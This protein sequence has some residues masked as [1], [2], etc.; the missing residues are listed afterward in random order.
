MEINIL[1][2]LVLGTGFAV[3]PVGADHC[4]FE[5][6]FKTLYELMPDTV[7]S[8]ASKVEYNPFNGDAFQ[9]SLN[10]LLVWRKVDNW[11]A[12]T[13]GYHTWINGQYGLQSRLNTE[14]F[15]WEP[16]SILS[17]NDPDFKVDLRKI[18]QQSV[19]DMAKERTY[20]EIFAG[21][22]PVTEQNPALYWKGSAGSKKVLTLTWT[23]WDGYPQ[24]E[25]REM[26]A[27]RDIWVTLVPEIRD[28]CAA[29]KPVDP[30]LDLE[31]RLGLPPESGKIYMV[32]IWADPNDMFRP[33][34]DPEISDREAELSF[35]NSRYI[36]ISEEYIDWFNTSQNTMYGVNGHPWTRLGY[37]YDWGSPDSPIGFSEYVIR[38]GAIIEIYQV[39]GNIEYC[40]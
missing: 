3:V 31:Q 39:K 34:P 13:N 19:D 28:Y 17:D 22:I 15:A 26:T 16:E 37:T 38:K 4:K 29:K 7:G 8:C 18:Y 32:E 11:T 5:L 1:L 10:G 27:T 40:R 36:T 20:N 23:D 35:P 33:S 30:V 25:G 12:F 24:N 21:L 14:R 9:H 6:G 2:A